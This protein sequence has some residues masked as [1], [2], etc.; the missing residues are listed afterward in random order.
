MTSN[1]STDDKKIQNL[2]TAASGK[3]KKKRRRT[4]DKAKVEENK[5]KAKARKE[6][7]RQQM[8]EEKA[9]SRDEKQKKR[10]QKETVM[11]EETVAVREGDALE[12]TV[13]MEEIVT[14]REDDALEQAVM[15]EET[16]TV[17]ETAGQI[18]ERKNKKEKV[19][20]EKVKKDKE[21][22]DKIQKETRQKPQGS[23]RRAVLAAGIAAVI[24]LLAGSGSFFGIRYYLEQLE[25]ADAAVEAMVHTE[26]VELAEYSMLQHKKEHVKKNAGKDVPKA[27]LD[28]ARFVLEGVK[29][30]P[31]EI[32]LTEENAADFATIESCVINTQTGKVD[33]TMS[34]EGL[35]VS[36]D[37]YYYLFEEKV[38]ESALTGEEYIIED[39]KDVDLT[40]SVNL[41]YNS[42]GSRLFSK[43]VVAVK[44]DGKFMAISRPRHITNPEAIARYSPAFGDTSSKKGLLVDPEKLR[45]SDLD[46]LGVKHAAYNIPLRRLLGNTTHA[47][48]PTVYYTYNGRNYAFNGQVVAEYDYIFSTLSGKGIII[49]AIILND[50]NPG[51]MDLIHPRARSGGAGSP[52]Y[53][54]NAA[55]EAG[56]EY[57]AAVASFLANRYAG[58]GHGKVMN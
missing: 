20:K 58:T 51:H 34:A 39:Q 9:R 22:K 24:V 57:I 44:K 47:S 31:P 49:T 5:K 42:A 1:K 8:K 56:T 4:I 15:V 21:Q 2:G 40:F 13:M 11:V 27:F 10:M 19:K 54:F 52:Y 37:G 12:Q 45:G 43:F 41:N 35:A 33:V 38:Y 32:E 25:T 53:A 36:D 29:N 6:R 23:R 26:A 28:A 55:D 30:R 46:D 17:K 48:Y 7:L 18:K 14:V 3:K 50:M 16:L